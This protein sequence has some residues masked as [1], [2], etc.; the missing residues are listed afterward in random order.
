M[1]YIRGT[2]DKGTCFICDAFNDRE[3][4]EERLVLWIDGG[5]LCMMNRFPYN[6]GH[7]M[8]APLTHDG[9]LES[10]AP[11]ERAALME[12]V[13]KAKALLDKVLSPDGF[14]IGINL[15]AIAGAGV[16]DHIHMHIVPRWNGDTNFMPVLSDTKIVP[17]ALEDLYARLRAE[18]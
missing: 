17:Q 15:G 11:A 13:V 2:K 12:G 5:T 8:V 3:H 10:L 7:L 9:A 18:L 4:M 6:N 1:Q 16:A 14:N